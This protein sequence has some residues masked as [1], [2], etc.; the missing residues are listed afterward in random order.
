MPSLQIKR[1]EYFCSL[2]KQRSKYQIPNAVEDTFILVTAL[3]SPRSIMDISINEKISRWKKMDCSHYAS[4]FPFRQHENG[5]RKEV[6]IKTRTVCDAFH[7]F[8]LTLRLSYI[9][10]RLC[11]QILVY[12]FAA[13]PLLFLFSTESPRFSEIYFLISFRPR[14]L[15]L[16]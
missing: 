5:S 12:P 4:D 13:F 2:L 14:I 9:G 6:T 10:K 11:Y 1:K 7:Y 16:R 8:R 15:C 3:R